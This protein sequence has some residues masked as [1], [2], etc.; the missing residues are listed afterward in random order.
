MG[1]SLKTRL[2][3][4][5][6]SLSLGKLLVGVAI[7]LIGSLVVVVW[8]ARGALEAQRILPQEVHAL[9]VSDSVQ[10]ESIKSVEAALLGHARDNEGEFAELRRSDAKQLAISVQ[11]LCILKLPLG[12]DPYDCIVT[13]DGG[14]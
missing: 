2:G 8:S 1:D 10:T 11:M 7:A 4:W 12:G 14:T 5:Q 9:Q 3:E 13:E 6:E